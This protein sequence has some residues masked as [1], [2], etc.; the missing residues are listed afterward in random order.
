MPKPVN[1]LAVLKDALAQIGASTRRSKR[2]IKHVAKLNNIDYLHLLNEI[3][4]KQEVL[5]MCLAK[6]LRL[7][8]R[9]VQK[10]G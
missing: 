4:R 5:E 10:N 9:K 7:E 1:N 3:I 8:Q 2:A 6:D